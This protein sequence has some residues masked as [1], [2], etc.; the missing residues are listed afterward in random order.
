VAAE[1]I[2]ARAA[3]I[4]EGIVLTDEQRARLEHIVR[5]A[6]ARVGLIMNN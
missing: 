4:A 3:E 2:E 6:K 5:T 1:G